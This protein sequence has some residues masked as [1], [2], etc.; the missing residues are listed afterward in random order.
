MRAAARRAANDSPFFALA[1]ALFIVAGCGAEEAPE[2]TA[3][4]PRSE[5]VSGPTV[6]GVPEEDDD[7]LVEPEIRSRLEAAEGGAPLTAGGE[8]I[9][10]RRTL[11]AVY[12]ER[13]FEP[14]WLE[15]GRVGEEG[16]ELVAQLREADR[17][18]LNPADYHL[19]AL[20]SLVGRLDQ[21]SDEDRLRQRVDVD[22][23]LTDAFLLFG[24]HLMHGRLD[25]VSVEPAWTA[26]RNGVD[27]GGIL[28]ASLRPGG[29][30]GALGS[31]R[32]SGDRYD[33]LRETLARY[34]EIAEAGGW[35][36]VP[37]GPTLDPGMEDPRVRALR[38]RLEAS[39][40]L[41]SGI[42]SSADPEL[43]DDLLAEAV[44][45]FQRR[46]GLDPDARVGSATVR[47]LNVSAAQRSEQLLVNLERWRWLPRDMGN[48][49]VLVNIAGYSVH[50]VAGGEEVMRLRAIV[51]TNYRRTP[52][53]SARMTYLALAPYWNVPPGIA[54]NDQLP[55]IREDPGYVARQNMVLFDNATNRRVD[56]HA[57][58]WSGMTGAQFN[59]LYRLRQ[60]PGPNNA[61]GN[62]KFMFPNQHNVYLHDTPARELFDRVTRTFSSGCIRVERAMELAEF[63]LSDDPE[64]TRE[65]LDQTVRQGRE[66]AVTLPRPVPVHVQYWT[67]WVEPDG[68][69]QFREDVYDR[70]ERVSAALR[71]PPPGV[72]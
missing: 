24:S 51:G 27:L 48:R 6:E 31:L 32:P 58:N 29:V 3:E 64:W 54:A 15:A 61:L 68:T 17:D 19:S 57:V 41:L 5:V 13:A 60:E 59:R 11:P 20:D 42:R 34:R 35:G 37:S 63:L 53:F 4:P 38:D 22:L 43:Y 71:S 72:N 36:T 52:V 16:L 46:H 10:S 55:R 7:L 50:V 45:G 39:G 12:R 28:L 23:L 49:Y 21:G 40:D 70:D 65:R 66:R 67:G 25:P 33:V 69:I 8:A 44:R 30:R 2:G 1:C 14:L 56:P 62:V 26:S 18:G 9:R 47:A